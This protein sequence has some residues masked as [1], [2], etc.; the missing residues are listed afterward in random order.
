MINLAI[1]DDHPSVIEGLKTMFLDDSFV[2][3][4]A[5]YSTGKA[6]V[7]GLKAQQAD[8]LLLDINLPDQN[9]IETCK[10]LLEY[11]PQLAIIAFTSY[12]DTRHLK[13]LLGLGAK[14]YMLKNS[15]YDEMHH[16]IL[17]VYDGGEYIQPEMKDE[18]V[19]ES[20]NRSENMS[21]IPKLTRREKEILQLILQE[22]TTQDMADKLFI[23]FK[24]VESHRLNLLQKLGVKNTAGLVRMAIEH[25]LV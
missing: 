14:G 15:S 22:H 11:I 19:K 23:S 6:T 2:K 4:V 17:T 12:K 8:V 9:G 21:Y 24:T 10:Q 13:E 25:K 5:V 1:T 16:A 20:L 7:D 3:I 18:L